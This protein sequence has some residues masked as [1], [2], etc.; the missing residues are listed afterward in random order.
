[1][2]TFVKHAKPGLPVFYEDSLGN[3]HPEE[4]VAVSEGNAEVVDDEDVLSIEGHR[5]RAKR[6]VDL[7]AGQCRTQYITCVEGQEMVYGIKK[8]E[9]AAYLADNSIDL[10]TVP[11]IKERSERLGITPLDV[12]TEWQGKADVWIAISPVIEGIRE[13]AKDSVEVAVD[14]AEIDVI[15]TGLSWP[16]PV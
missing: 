12:A 10:D 4:P 2:E 11:H 13:G 6:Q 9:A 7:L 3:V 14:K 5:S 15:M 16:V 8:A 1:M